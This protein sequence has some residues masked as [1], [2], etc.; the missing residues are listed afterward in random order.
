MFHSSMWFTTKQ[1]WLLLD[2]YIFLIQDESDIEYIK[3]LRDEAISIYPN[4]R[5]VLTWKSENRIK[6]LSQYTL[7]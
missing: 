1:Q 2:E 5:D 7:H 4:A 6:K 3:L